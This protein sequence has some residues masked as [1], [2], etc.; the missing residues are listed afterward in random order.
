LPALFGSVINTVLLRHDP[1]FAYLD[2]VL[3]TAATL[4]KFMKQI[5]GIRLAM[6]FVLC[7]ALTHARQIVATNTDV[8]VK[9]I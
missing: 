6:L 4:E 2:E 8:A 5:R 9:C 3:S 7:S 1:L